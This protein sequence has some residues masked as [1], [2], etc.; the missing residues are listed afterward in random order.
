[1][2]GSRTRRNPW[3]CLTA[4]HV[5]PA[6]I[7]VRPPPAGAFYQAETYHQDFLVRPPDSPYIVINEIPKVRV[8]QTL[9]PTLYHATPVTVLPL[10]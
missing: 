4:A 8:L 3:L 2:P 6:P 10:N 9:F 1:M 5:V 7:A